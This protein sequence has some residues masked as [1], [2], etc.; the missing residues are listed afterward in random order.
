MST[1]VLAAPLY[2]WNLYVEYLWNYQQ[3]SWVDRI[4][5]TFRVLALLLITP[6]AILTML[7]RDQILHSPESQPTL[8]QPRMSRRT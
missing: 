7:V 3:N 1:T 2:L 4:A 8:L 5:S 6:F